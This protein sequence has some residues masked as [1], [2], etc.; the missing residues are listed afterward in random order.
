M[1]V[2]GVVVLFVELGQVDA[3][4]VPR[5]ARAVEIGHEE[6]VLFGRALG[7]DRLEPTPETLEA[8]LTGIRCEVPVKGGWVCGQCYGGRGGAGRVVGAG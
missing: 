4:H 1:L 5:V 2:C 8:S 7:A 3:H 6:A